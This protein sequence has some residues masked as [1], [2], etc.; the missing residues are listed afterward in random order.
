MDMTELYKQLD[1]VVEAKTFS[2]EATRAIQALR[3]EHEKTVEHNLLLTSLLAGAK[4]EN[5][6]L[7]KSLDAESRKAAELELEVS[8]IEAREKALIIRENSA[9]EQVG[10]STA[11]RTI[12]ELMFKNSTVRESFQKGTVTHVMEASQY[13][14]CDTEKRKGRTE[15]TTHVERTTL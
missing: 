11:Y 6:R 14:G 7:F 9:A 1:V 15:E 2:L 5:S 10:Q 3:R 8:K 12:F 4:E 13:G